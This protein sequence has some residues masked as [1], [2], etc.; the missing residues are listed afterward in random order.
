M[1]RKPTGPGAGEALCKYES[2]KMLRHAQKM[3]GSLWTLLW[4]AFFATVKTNCFG[5]IMPTN[6]NESG[7]VFVLAIS[8]LL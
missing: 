7:P 2:I 1:Q 5:R 3:Q 4:K 8:T 6:L